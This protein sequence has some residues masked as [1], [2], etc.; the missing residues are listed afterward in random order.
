MQGFL[1]K[2]EF[3]STKVAKWWRIPIYG[4]Y[5][6][7][8]HSGGSSL[9]STGAWRRRADS[10]RRIEVLQ[11]SALTTWLRRLHRIWIWCRGG[12]SNSYG[13]NP[14][15][16]SRQRVYQFHH[17]GSIHK[18]GLRPG[19]NPHRTSLNY[20][21]PKMSKSYVEGLRGS[22]SLSRTHIIF[23]LLPQIKN[24]FPIRVISINLILTIETTIP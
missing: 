14:T 21:H 18:Q 11:T 12:D 20:K 10:N 6:N 1:E 19:T 9:L 15:A 8:W 16:P 23:C 22:P 17:L 7:T 13:F 5:N 3:W 2:Y 4:G 24:R